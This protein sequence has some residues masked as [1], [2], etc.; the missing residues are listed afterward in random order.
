VA[1]PSEAFRERIMQTRTD[2]LRKRGGLGVAEDFDGLPC[3]VHNDAAV[4]AF[5]KMLLEFRASCR[6]KRVVEIIFQLAD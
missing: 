1:V 5:S 6:V 3:R 4:L 2:I